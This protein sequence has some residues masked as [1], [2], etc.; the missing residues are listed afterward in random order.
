MKYTEAKQGRVF[1]I[2]LEDGDIIHEEIEKFA[3]RKSIKA[4]SLIIIG[5]ADKGSKLIVG[6]KQGRSQSITPMVHILED[7]HQVPKILE[8]YLIVW[9]CLAKKK[10]IPAPVLKIILFLEK[11]YTIQQNHLQCSS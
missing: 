1:V 9:G 4:A 3:T 11:E 2:R 7:V 6:P 8:I 10:A 5:G